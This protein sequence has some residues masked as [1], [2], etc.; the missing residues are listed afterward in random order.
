MGSGNTGRRILLVGDIRIGKPPLNGE[1]VKNQ[2]VATWLEGRHRLTLVDTENW[3]RRPWVIAKLLLEMWLGRH[4]TILVSASSASVH[5]LFR[6]MRP[7]RRTLA[8]T[9]YLVIGGY[10]PTGIRT[11]R[12]RASSYAG[13]KG[14]IVEGGSMRRQLQELGVDAPVHVIP[15]V[16]PIRGVHGDTERYT[17][18]G[19]T[20]FLFVGRIAEPKGTLAVME[21]LGDP[22]LRDRAGELQVDYFGKTEE[23]HETAFRQ[24]L[25]RHGNCAYKGYLDITRD[26]AGAYAIFSGYHAM[27]FPT[28]WIGEGFPGVIIDA[29]TCG[30]P[31]IASDW[32]MNREVVQ[33]GVTGRVIP[34]GDT[35][36]LAAAMAS[37]MDDRG[38]WA[39][40][41]RACHEA[42][43]Q[44]DVDLVLPR[45]LE[46]LL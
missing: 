34:A 46:P 41:S 42:V 27:L 45:L 20:R 44:F 15:N 35:A 7:F 10:L 12:Y 1:Q 31:V 24:A 38:E 9:L 40:L 6:A 22:L 25:S 21:A 26:P 29:Y 28:T 43:R 11:G 3:K 30:L 39:R 36:A 13:L 8:K 33:D 16:K 5:T 18:E 4:D 2:I 19:A 17:R 14:I 37:V 23:A 32:N